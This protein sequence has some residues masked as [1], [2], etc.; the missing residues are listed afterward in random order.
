MS[1]EGSPFAEWQVSRILIADDHPLM[2]ES[3]RQV[4]N[5]CE[6]LEI[7]GEAQNGAEALELCHALRPD[8]VL[9]DARM[10]EMDG[11]EATC[12]IKRELP[13]TVVLILTAFENPKYLFEALKAG[14][15]GYVLKSAPPQQIVES[16]RR[17]LA[18]EPTL[19]QEVAMRLFLR[20]IEEKQRKD[21]PIDF[22]S[23]REPF[24]ERQEPPVVE[25][26]TQREVEVLTLLARGQ[27]N[28]EIAEHLFI[29]VSTV[30]N[31]V[32]RVITKL[33][34]SDRVQAVTLAI[35]RGLLSLWVA[36]LMEMWLAD[37]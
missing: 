4:L 29:S 25:P 13:S 2:R 16:V 34:A 17:V 18:G 26:L 11:L 6:G 19:N 36:R 24:E 8:L 12:E 33:G 5:R 30:K 3:L 23:P 10:P 14:A 31:H 37:L 7:V 9:M 22:A 27:T 20:L 32:H 1:D 35:E 21:E 28:R 15:S